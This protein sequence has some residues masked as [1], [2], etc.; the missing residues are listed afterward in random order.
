[1]V[2]SRETTNMYPIYELSRELMKLKIL[3]ILSGFGNLGSI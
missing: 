1:M 2:F 3:F